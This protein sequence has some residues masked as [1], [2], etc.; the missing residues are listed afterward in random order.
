MEKYRM[1]YAFEAITKVVS[2]K[3]VYML[4]KKHRNVQCVNDMTLDALAE[5]LR[6]EDSGWAEDRFA[7]WYAEECEE[8]GEL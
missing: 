7:F 2:G 4:D 5:V 8:N 6:I 3:T 1:I